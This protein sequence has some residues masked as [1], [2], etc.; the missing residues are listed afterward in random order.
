MVSDKYTL[1]LTYE[2]QRWE[3]LLDR[4]LSNQEISRKV[5]SVLDRYLDELERSKV[6]DF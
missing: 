1:D 6:G 2:K 5:R 4:H 3:I